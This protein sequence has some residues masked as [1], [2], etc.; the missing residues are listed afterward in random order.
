MSLCLDIVGKAWTRILG[1]DIINER[2][3]YDMMV[4]DYAT[5]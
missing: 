4:M 2:D 1:M 5:S 3:A